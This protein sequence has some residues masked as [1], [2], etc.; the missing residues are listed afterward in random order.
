MDLLRRPELR[1]RLLAQLRGVE[2]VVLLGDS[3]ELRDGPLEDAIET[4]TP[5]FEDLAETLGG[6][7]VTVVPGNHDHQLASRWLRRRRVKQS[8]RPLGLE[9]LSRPRRGDPLAP[10]ARRMP[11]TELVLA[12]PGLW[13]RPDVYATHGHYLDCHNRVAT[14]E[15]MAL[16]VIRTMMLSQ[17]GSF[18]EAEDYEAVVA[19]LYGAIHRM[20][21]SRRGRRAATV[22]KFLV[23]RWERLLGFRGPGGHARRLP[24]RRPPPSFERRP[25]LGAM[26]QVLDRLRIEADWVLFGHLHR[27]GEWRSGQ[28]TRILNTGSWVYEPAYIGA[29]ATSS[30]YWP[31]ACAFVRDGQPPELRSML[32]RLTDEE[33]RAGR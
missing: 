16:A 18:R 15:C 4:A 7:R 19:P 13:L 20:V 6:G 26:L 27:R 29:A 31:G 30:P 22:G 11:G 23:R 21:Q 5:L 12:Y 33:L 10:L 2:H 1:S 24:G 17:P 8:P 9:Q 3:I 28:G 32:G 25:G 14:F